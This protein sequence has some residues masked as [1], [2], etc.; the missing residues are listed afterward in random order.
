MIVIFYAA[1]AAWFFDRSPRSEL[2]VSCFG[3]LIHWRLLMLPIDVLLR[4]RAPEARLIQAGDR[5]ARHMRAGLVAC[6]FA[7]G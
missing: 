7:F 1:H 2:A 6:C 4:P 5:H 3:G